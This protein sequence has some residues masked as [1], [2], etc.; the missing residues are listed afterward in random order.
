MGDRC[1]I[2]I[3]SKKFSAALVKIVKPQSRRADLVAEGYT[4]IVD[5]RNGHLVIR[6]PFRG[7]ESIKCFSHHLGAPFCENA[8]A[9]IFPAVPHFRNPVSQVGFLIGQRPDLRN[10]LR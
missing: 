7:L 6:S 9:E 5:V 10:Q 2:P 8:R 3:E 4:A 1:Q